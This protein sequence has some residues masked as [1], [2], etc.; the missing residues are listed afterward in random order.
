QQLETL[1]DILA[2]IES[3]CPPALMKRLL[4]D[5]EVLEPTHVDAIP[6]GG[7]AEAR[8]GSKIRS[9]ESEPTIGE[10]HIPNRPPAPDPRMPKD[11]SSVVVDK[12]TPHEHSD[13]SDDIPTVRRPRS[14]KELLAGVVKRARKDLADTLE[15]WELGNVPRD[16]AHFSQQCMERKCGYSRMIVARELTKDGIKD[17]QIF[18]VQIYDVAGYG[19]HTFT[20][21]EIAPQRY[22]LIDATFAQFEGM[23]Q[24][25]PRVGERI[26]R[27]T[28]PLGAHIRTELLFKGY[29]EL[30]D[31]IANI[32]VKVVS[33]LDHGTY[34]VKD[35]IRP[36]WSLARNRDMLDSVP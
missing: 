29:V 13:F 10:S 33:E 17:S 32:Y 31:E 35:L 18:M 2:K 24:G 5:L 4:P 15:D 34:T 7:S 14:E 25:A 28:G 23:F 12:S 36:E 20:I 21:V 30:N 22:I 8:G 3:R 11:T 27:E 16:R 9:S 19:R 26:L 1:K 6:R